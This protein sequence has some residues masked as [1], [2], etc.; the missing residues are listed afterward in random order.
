MM[1]LPPYWGAATIAGAEAAQELG[2]HG[3]GKWTAENLSQRR[4]GRW[5]DGTGAKATSPLHTP[6]S[7][8]I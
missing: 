5:Q 2:E 7:H 3:V 8:W 6:L 4:G 1:Q